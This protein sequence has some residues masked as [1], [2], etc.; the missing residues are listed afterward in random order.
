MLQRIQNW[1]KIHKVFVVG[2]CLAFLAILCLGW[3]GYTLHTGTQNLNQYE[4]LHDEYI[5]RQGLEPI[6]PADGLRQTLKVDKATPLYGMRLMFATF[7]RVAK[8]SITLQLERGGQLLATSANDMTMLL[9]GAFVDFVFDAPVSLE[10]N[11]EYSLVLRWQPAAQEDQVL[12]VCGEG[13]QANRALPLTDPLA[14][15]ADKPRTA[16]MQL[17]V[18]HTGSRYGLTLFLPVAVLVFVTL[19]VGFW[20]I[21]VVKAKAHISFV[22]LAMGIGLALCLVIPPLAGPDEYVHVTAAYTLASEVLQQTSKAE[23]PHERDEISVRACDADFMRKDSG[24]VGIFAYKQMTDNLFSTGNSGALTHRV[25]V[26]AP[27]NIRLAQYAPQTVGVLLARVLG[28]GFFAMLLLGRICNLVCYVALAALALWLVPVGKRL[29]CAVAL[30]PM[31]LQL[32]ATFSVDAALIGLCFVFTALCLKGAYAEKPFTTMNRV[33]LVV[34]AVLL[35]PNKALYIVLLALCLIIPNGKLGG[36]WQGIGLKALVFAGGGLAWF[37]SNGNMIGHLLQGIDLE[38]AQKML[39][40]VCVAA[41]LLAYGWYVGK[42]KP[43]VRKCMLAVALVLVLALV[44]GTAWVLGNSGRVLT[45]E[46][47][48]A[49]IQPNGESVYMFQLSYILFNLPQTAKLLVNTITRQLPLYLQGIVGALPGE[50]IVYGLELSWTLTIG[51]LLVLI[52]SSTRRIDQPRR[53]KK[54]HAAGMAAVVVVVTGLMFVAC[55]DWTPI[56]SQIIFGMQGRYLLPVLPLAL[57]LL[58][59]NSLVTLRRSAQKGLCLCS[60]V[61]ALV[62]TLESLLLFALA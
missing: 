23:R 2:L 11:T 52:A 47:Y 4:I 13:L 46:E 43:V 28:L 5:E 62:A 48:A 42:K 26:R 34:L 50:P 41:A 58:G 22:A 40:P 1:V 7:E 59:E 35:A 39:L 31:C 49:G 54:G 10:K 45:A 53:L 18:N 3:V 20:L 61:L 56:N 14:T 33:A 37:S 6:S 8:G 51:L 12:L 30:L 24:K 44:A 55:L 21:F 36:K 60:G 15:S 32:A 9:D 29:F 19:M 16:V 27:F 25:M 17:I 57:L 38:R